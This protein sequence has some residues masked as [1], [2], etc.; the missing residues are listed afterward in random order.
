M[1][2][3]IVQQFK[4]FSGS[5]VVLMGK[6]GNLFVRKTGNIQRNIERIEALKDRYPVPKIFTVR[7]DTMDIEYLHGLDMR[8]YL[9]S[10]SVNNLSNFI[11]NTFEKMSESV[12]IKDYSSTYKSFFETVDFSDLPFNAIELFN[13]LP[14]EL[15][16]SEYHGDFTLENIIYHNDSFVLIDCSNGVWDSFIFDIAKMRQDLECKWFLRNSPAMIENKLQ[17]IQRKLF[18]HWPNSN[19]NYLLI[20]MLLRVYRY[21]YNNSPEHNL[22]QREIHRLWK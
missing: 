19:N 13:K 7:G 15:P 20:L 1:V 5:V 3:R 14:K 11:I 17:T 18:E 10:Y 22:I 9:I 4:G 21:T 8:S 12:T 2:A 16:Q 6:R